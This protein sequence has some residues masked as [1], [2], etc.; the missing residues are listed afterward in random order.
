MKNTFIA[1]LAMLCFMLQEPVALIAAVV[2][3]SV[4]G[5]QG[6]RG[7]IS[8][9]SALFLMVFSLFSL[10]AFLSFAHGV[11]P[12]FYYVLVLVVFFSAKKMARNPV[13]SLL[14]SYQTSFYVY[15]IAVLLLYYIHREAAEPFGEIL[16]GVSTN[17]IPSYLIVLQVVLSLV[18][19][20]TTGRLPLFS[21]LCTLV[22][23]I[24][25][26]G[27]GSILAACMIVALSVF[28]NILLAIKHRHRRA[29]AVYVFGMVVLGIAG[30]LHFDMVYQFLNGRTKILHG[31]YDPYRAAMF[32]QYLDQIT[33][34]SLFTGAGYEGTDIETLYANNPHIAFIR[35][36]AYLG[37]GG[38]LLVFISPFFLFMMRGE[39]MKKLIFLA[40][41][42]VLFF[43]ALSES[44]LFPTLLDF[45]FCFIL[46]FYYFHGRNENNASP[47]ISI[48][49]GVA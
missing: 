36:H 43:R 8:V 24:L 18:A 21:T 23:A 2:V 20:T 14:K 39:G 28:F 11:S 33:P 37:I 48:R 35:T 12:Y 26:I 15:V 17:G 22:V 45:F 30:M 10:P 6:N 34:M 49:V 31:L 46:W 3:L 13:H 1:L 38:L 42:S 44:I 4:Y 27:R 40:F 9:S 32:T 5:V 41:L 47:Q 7:T 16:E 19:Y 25:G 29:V